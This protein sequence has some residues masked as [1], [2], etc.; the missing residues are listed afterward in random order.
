MR[1]WIGIAH[2]VEKLV[3]F[4][5]CDWFGNLIVEGHFHFNVFRCSLINFWISAS[6]R[7][8]R[9]VFSLPPQSKRRLQRAILLLGE[10]K[11]SRDDD[12]SNPLSTDLVLWCLRMEQ[13]AMTDCLGTSCNNMYLKILAS[14]QQSIKTFQFWVVVVVVV[15]GWGWGWGVGWVAQ[16]TSCD[17]MVTLGSI[18]MNF[19]QGKS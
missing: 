3:I 5:I 16:V 4:Q 18:V 15:M 13:G 2:L 9:M 12:L 6:S 17:Y 11:A 14:L 8:I 7:F 19:V 10:D 1:H